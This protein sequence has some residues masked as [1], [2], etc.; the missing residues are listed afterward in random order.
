MNSISKVIK[1]VKDMWKSD[2][3]FI[4]GVIFFILA[5]IGGLWALMIFL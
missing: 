1:E 5:I 2:N 4:A 3:W